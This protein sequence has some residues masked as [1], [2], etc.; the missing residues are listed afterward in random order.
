ML[1]LTEKPSVAKDFAAVLSCTYD[2]G[3]YRNAG[4]DIA[5]I[6]CIGHLFALE[7]PAHYGTELPIIPDRFDYLINPAV[8]KQAGLV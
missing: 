4:R 5:V 1:I 8:E 2:R 7:E 6:N 3:V